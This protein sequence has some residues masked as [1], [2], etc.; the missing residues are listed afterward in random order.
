VL[1]RREV[2]LAEPRK[3]GTVDLRAASDDVVH[4]GSERV[5]GTVEPLLRG[6]VPPVEEDRARRPVLRLVRHALAALQHEDVD[7]STR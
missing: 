5:A 4:A 6:L 7:A 3:A 1:D 2:L